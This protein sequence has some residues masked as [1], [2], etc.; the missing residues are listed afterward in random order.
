MSAVN[1][2][3]DGLSSTKLDKKQMND[4]I[5]ELSDQV[6]RKLT[7]MAAQGEKKVSSEAVEDVGKQ[8]D[9]FKQE[10]AQVE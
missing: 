3:V 5:K 10:A 7:I 9:F 2:R 8:T 6:T 1:S 4:T